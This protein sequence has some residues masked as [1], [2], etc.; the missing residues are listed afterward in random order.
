M[1]GLHSKHDRRQQFR[2]DFAK[3]IFA[4]FGEDAGN[5]SALAL[6]DLMVHI[7]EAPTQLFR[8][9]TAHRCFAGTHEADEV[10]ARSALEFQRHRFTSPITPAYFIPPSA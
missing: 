1:P 2:F 4:R 10:Q 6:L 3:A 7:D 9:G 8:N 5:R